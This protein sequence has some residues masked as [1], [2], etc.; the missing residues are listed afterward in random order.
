[1]ESKNIFVVFV[2]SP[3]SVQLFATSWTAACQDSEIY[4]RTQIPQ[5]YINEDDFAGIAVLLPPW[6][7]ELFFY[8]DCFSVYMTQFY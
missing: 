4:T 3:S 2:Q 8:S 1:M 5:R 6:V 7:G